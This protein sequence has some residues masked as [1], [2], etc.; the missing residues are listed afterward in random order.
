MQPL[1]PIREVSLCNG[2]VNAEIHK[3]PEGSVSVE[4]M[5]FPCK[6]C[7]ELILRTYSLTVY[8]TMWI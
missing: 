7:P 1:D 3:Q 8:V 5:A 2:V 6:C 4:S